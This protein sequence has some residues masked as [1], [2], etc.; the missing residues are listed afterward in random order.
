MPQVDVVVPCYNYGRFLEQCVGSVLGQGD[1][2]VRVLIIDDASSDDT[3]EIG[4]NIAAREPRV[5]FRRHATNR[6]HIAT[7]NEGLLHWAKA[8][9]ALL[10]SADDYLLPGALARATALMDRH[11]EVGFVFGSAFELHPGAT[12]PVPEAG[13]TEVARV[14][15]GVEFIKMS[16]AHNIVP[17][18]TAVV[19]TQLQK[20]IG[21][22][23]P[24]LPH[25]GDM[26]MWLRFAS[27]GQV[28]MVATHQ[29]VYRRHERNMSLSYSVDRV[30]MLPDMRQRALVFARFFAEHA[31]RLSDPAQLRALTVGALANEAMWE[32]HAAFEEGRADVCRDLV[33]FATAT[34]PGVRLTRPW[35]SL[36]VKRSLGYR[37]WLALAPVIARAQ[38][39]RQA[40]PVR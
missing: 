30:L 7:Y 25:A 34:C 38:D 40:R 15:D 8:E 24:D 9:Y 13:K 14:L 28:G 29:A 26:E 12:P 18:A 37:T 5:E 33:E 22:Y 21:G 27:H 2:D 31:P 35:L 23:C 1:V 19:R 4:G 16:G 10:L 36:A 3:P 39:V 11:P 20:K 6:G 17:T 32:A